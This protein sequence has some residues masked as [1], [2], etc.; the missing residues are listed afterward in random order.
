L[1]NFKYKGKNNWNQVSIWWMCIW[2]GYYVAW[3]APIVI[4]FPIVLIIVAIVLLSV[5]TKK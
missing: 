3:W 2:E 1:N 4:Y 5:L